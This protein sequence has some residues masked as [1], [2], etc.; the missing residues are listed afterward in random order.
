MKRAAITFRMVRLSLIWISFLWG[1]GDDFLPVGID[2]Q[3]KMLSSP[4]ACLPDVRCAGAPAVGTKLPWRHR[5]KSALVVLAGSPMHRGLDLLEAADSP[6]QSIR[7]ELKYGLLDKSLEDEDLEVFACQAGTWQRL[8]T[9]TTDA[10]GR[11]S[12]TLAGA[13][14]LPVGRRTLF[15]SVLGDRSSFRML[16]LVMPPNGQTVVS[17]IDGTLTSSENA[18]P[19]SLISGAMV[20]AQDAAADAIATLEQRC[21]Q[22]VYLTA[23]P[24]AYTEITRTWL[25]SRGFPS[26]PLRLSPYRLTLPGD[27]TVEYKAAALAEIQADHVGTAIGIGNRASDAQAYQRAGIPHIFLKGPE[28][29]AEIDPI[30]ASG[31]ATGIDSYRA[32]IPVFAAFPK[33][34]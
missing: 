12:M 10:E 1:C 26:G 8:G 3:E 4:G 18:F 29:A 9:A 14:R 21:Y 34:P 22:P 5:I 19:E 15:V 33:A 11:F 13:S 23:R 6:T 16:A 24:R 30:I 31:A 28:F 32:I 27:P 20:A 17:D 7:G 25:A 2:P